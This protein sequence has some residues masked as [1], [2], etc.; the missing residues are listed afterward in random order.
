MSGEPN[1]GGLGAADPGSEPNGAGGQL[2]FAQLNREHALSRKFRTL[3]T[4]SPE[5]KGML[6]MHE[7]ATFEPLD[8]NQQLTAFVQNTFELIALVVSIV[9][10]LCFPSLVSIGFVLLAHLPLIAS[11]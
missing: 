2:T 3:F 5:T 9:L 4:V 7:F 11:K 6:R 1:S 8:A 10:A